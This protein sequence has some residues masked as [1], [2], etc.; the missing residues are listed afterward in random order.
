MG[1]GVMGQGARW[2]KGRLA[3][4]RN[5]ASS[6]ALAAGRLGGG[7]LFIWVGRGWEH[8]AACWRGRE[9]QGVPCR[10]RDR[11]LGGLRCVGMG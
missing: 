2:V 8:G 5:V 1:V 10:G 3:I 7:G 9:Q 11:A 4:H 6:S